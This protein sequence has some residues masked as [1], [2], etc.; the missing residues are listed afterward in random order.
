ML[1]CTAVRVLKICPQSCVKE[2]RSFDGDARGPSEP[3]KRVISVWKELFGVLQASNMA[4]APGKI[5]HTC[6]EKYNKYSLSKEELPSRIVRS[7]YNLLFRGHKCLDNDIHYDKIIFI[8]KGY[9]LIN[10][11]CARTD[12]VYLCPQTLPPLSEGAAPPD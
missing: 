8:T 6:F 4:S 1:S 12:L 7:L 11:S 5:C 3:C 9:A 2:R 10:Y